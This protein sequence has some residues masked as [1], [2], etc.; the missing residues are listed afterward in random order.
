VYL[1]VRR[2][3]NHQPYARTR[4]SEKEHVPVWEEHTKSRNTDDKSNRQYDN[5]TV[6]SAALLW[7]M[8]HHTTVTT[9]QSTGHSLQRRHKSE[10]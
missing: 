1:F 5:D 7:F 2:K 8:V 4:P 9:L 6:D 10:N 3:R